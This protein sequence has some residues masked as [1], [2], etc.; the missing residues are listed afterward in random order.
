MKRRHFVASCGASLAWPARLS[1]AAAYPD[2]AI[3]LYQGYAPGGNADAIADRAQC[4]ALPVPAGE[5]VV[6]G[7]ERHARL[8]ARADD[9]QFA[10]IVVGR[11]AERRQAG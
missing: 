9:V 5:Q 3:K 1:F 8:E 6:A 4:A 2:K 10:A 11:R 7:P